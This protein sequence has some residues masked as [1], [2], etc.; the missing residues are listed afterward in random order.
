[1]KTMENGKRRVTFGVTSVVAGRRAMEV[2]PQLIATSTAGGFRVTGPVTTALRLQ[3]G[4]Y[5][6]FA[7]NIDTITAGIIGKGS[8]E[9]VALNT[10]FQQYVA[11]QGLEWGTPAA[12][13]AIHAAYDLYFICKGVKQLDKNG[14]AVTVS[15]RL[16]KEERMAFVEANY[17]E[18]LAAA[19]ENGSDKLKEILANPEAT[20]EQKKEAL[21]SCVEAD[22]VEKYTGSRLATPSGQ[23]GTGLNLNF[24]DTNMWKTLKADL[25]EAADTVNRVYP[26]DL[27]DVIMLEVSNGFGVEQVPAFAFSP[28]DFTDEKPQR[29]GA[30]E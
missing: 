22:E 6:Q 24:S 1:M 13:A 19:L 20:D 18:M 16:T 9:I 14:K 26:I 12:D 3:H 29:V 4:D 17:D 10:E 2:E 25:G 21:C 11:E 15:A 27:E 28:A 30:K 23:I 8:A 7:H 5:I